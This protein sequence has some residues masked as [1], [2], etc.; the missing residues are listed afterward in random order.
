[1]SSQQRR[2][3]TGDP[4]STT[5]MGSGSV[6]SSFGLFDALENLLKGDHRSEDIL[7]GGDWMTMS[8]MRVWEDRDIK[9]KAH[10]IQCTYRIK[11]LVC[12]VHLLLKAIQRPS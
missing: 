5:I 3:E 7:V 12:T 11:P 2:H 6:S 9:S 1:M 8:E 4:Q 10:Y